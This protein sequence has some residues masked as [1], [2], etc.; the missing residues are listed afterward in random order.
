[1]KEIAIA[2]LMAVSAVSASAYELGVTAVRDYAGANSTAHGLTLGTK[3][4]GFG[5]TAGFERNTQGKNDQDRLSLVADRTL[6]KSGRVSVAAR[7]GV[8]HLDNARGA[9]GYALVAGL[10]AS[11]ALTKSTALTLALDRQYGQD[12]V[13]AHDGNRVTLG[14]KTSF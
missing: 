5:V 10:G 2:A 14:V 8:A 13:S 4:S 9:D 12:R 6:V 7:A 11:Y 3:V 1:M